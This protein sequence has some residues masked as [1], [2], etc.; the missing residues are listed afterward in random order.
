MPGNRPGTAPPRAAARLAGVMPVI[1][2]SLIIREEGPALIYPPTATFDLSRA[3]RYE[4]TRTWSAAPPWVWCM[5]NPST[6]SAFASDQTITR[7]CGFAAAGGAGGIIVVNLFAW[8]SVSPAELVCQLDPVGGQNDAFI[9]AACPPGRMVIAA[10]GV[11][12]TL[13]N[14]A[15]EVTAMLE[16]AGVE[17]YCLG[18]TMGGHPR[19]PSRLAAAVRPVPCQALRPAT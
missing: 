5:L 7:C 19:H 10:W 4:L 12:G 1:D 14:R 15:A 11:H 8:R 3:Y 9:M 2:E 17:L 6:A 18:V 16:Q 13:R